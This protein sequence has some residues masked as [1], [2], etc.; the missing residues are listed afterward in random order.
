MCARRVDL[1]NKGRNYIS[2][3]YILKLTHILGAMNMIP[4]HLMIQRQR[5]KLFGHII[6][7]KD[8]RQMKQLL[9][10]EIDGVRFRGRPNMQWI[11]CII[12]DLKTFNISDNP[13][14]EWTK[15]RDFALDRDKWKSFMEGEGM[16]L[17][18]IQWM[19]KNRERRKKRMIRQG[20]VP[21]QCDIVENMEF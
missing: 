14:E 3:D 8:D 12:E 11:D 7:M 20:I 10:G 16:D 19:A 17:A 2:Y 4:M 15:I 5:L 6:R 21:V 1:R 13:K 18:V 9:F